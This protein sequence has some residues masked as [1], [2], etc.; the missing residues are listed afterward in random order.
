MNKKGN[1]NLRSLHTSVIVVLIVS[2]ISLVGC[3]S[4]KDGITSVE[5]LVKAE[6]SFKILN[7]ENEEMDDT[8]KASIMSSNQMGFELIQ[9]M[10]KRDQESNLLLS[11]TSLAFALAMLEN[12]A[13]GE[14]KSGILKVLGEE[15]L[16]INERYNAWMNYLNALDSGEDLETP[17]IKMKVANSLW[18]RENLELKKEFVNTLGI[19]YNAQVYRSDFSDPKT[20]DQMNQWVEDQTNHLLKGTFDRIDA[21]T[22]VYLMNTV[23]FKG[24]WIDEFHEL[25]TKEEPFFK[26]E[27]D[28]TMVNMM[29]KTRRL[30]YQEDAQYQMTR[31][32]YYGGSSLVLILPKGNL[33]DFLSTLKYD[34][35]KKM[36]Y[37]E[38]D[39]W[40]ELDLSLPK[41]DYEVSNP[42]VDLLTEKG[43]GRAFSR[44]E[45]EFGNMVEIKDENVYISSIFQNARI[46]L[47]EKGTEA[48]AVTVVE[49][50][51]TSAMPSEPVT[52]K[53]D[54]PFLYLIKDDKTGAVLFVGI[55]REP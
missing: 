31:L 55:V 29:H 45:A 32:P 2:L 11:P 51:T 23:Y 10:A 49:A 26:T 6:E 41:F 8:V 13:E 12:G 33:N 43:M 40:Q 30:A 50:K 1:R 3:T 21:D 27:T 54:K 37:S 4:D 14:T 18:F 48:A 47:D 44:E 5:G 36:I 19:F 7:T 35:L 28:K 24:T 17:G 42:L 16:E 22:I 53:C 52:F 25:A 39:Q 9:E 38:P 46:I 15:E 20:V 34:D